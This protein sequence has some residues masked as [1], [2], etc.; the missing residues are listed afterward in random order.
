MKQFI[1]LQYNKQ[2]AQL[3]QRDHAKLA[4]VSINFQLYSLSQ[5]I[6]VFEPPYVDIG[7]YKHFV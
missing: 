2:V 4:S 3:W 5:T 7:Q 1:L 6:A